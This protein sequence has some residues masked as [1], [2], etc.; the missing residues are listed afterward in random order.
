MEKQTEQWS[1][2]LGFILSSAG[3]AVGL[4][5][6]WKFPYM[7]GMNGG[8]A[9]FFIFIFFTVLI[10]LP[11]LIAEFVVGR[12]AQK[13][14]V[15][16]FQKLAPK[17]IFSFIG[18]WGV[19]GAFI[20]MSFYSV[21]GGWVLIY[22]LLSIPG[23]VIKDGADY[24]G[25]FG[26]ITE[27]P[28][29]TVAALAVFVFINS[30]VIS[31]G[32]KNGIEKYSKILMPL[33]FIFFIIIVIRALT[34]EG[35]M[36]GVRFFLQPDFSQLNGENILYALGQAFFSLAVGISVM[37]TYSS[38][39]SKDVSLTK[40]A[41]SVSIMNIMVSLL[42]G[43]A[44]FPIVFSF[45]LEPTEGPKLLFIVLPEAF[46]QMPFG[47]VFL[48]LFLLLFLFAILTSSF[49]MLE[50]ITSAVH[51]KTKANRKTIAWIAGLIVFIAGIPA[52]LSSNL[53]A[54]FHIFGKTVFDA[55]DFLV[56]NI[57][58]PGGCLLIA[59]FVGFKMDRKLVEQEFH[60]GSHWRNGMF[61]TWYQLLRWLAP[62]TIV[63][64]F[65][66]SLGVI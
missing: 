52:A 27:N 36:E 29:I 19:V 13:E 25:L 34:F 9:F 15:S 7:T 32:I 12:G 61:Q 47:E 50:I 35:A 40:S 20:L 5:A 62:I 37:V 39:L 31:N 54:D 55:S 48:C 46:S 58:L 59:L 16:A 14:A 30:F 8:G 65:L 38:Y 51:E 45:G 1:T 28:L 2:K 33:L 18:K 17:S 42:A 49:S 56:S 63:V 26:M 11:L 24:T 57:M 6:I 22:S 66:Y 21:V 60:A 64:V 41:A 3:A 53:L 4:G 44:V 10:G 43:L 23:M